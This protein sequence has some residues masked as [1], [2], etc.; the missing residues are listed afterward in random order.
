MYFLIKRDSL[1]TSIISNTKHSPHRL[2]LLH[3]ELKD[4]E[5]TLIKSLDEVSGEGVY[6]MEERPNCYRIFKRVILPDGYLFSGSHE[7][8]VIFF[9]D[10]VHY[11]LVDKVNLTH[12]LCLNQELTPSKEKNLPP[13]LYDEEYPALPPKLSRQNAY[14]VEEMIEE[15]K[16]VNAV[17]KCIVRD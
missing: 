1:T 17:K 12:E 10:L 9:Y 13:G 16:K 2:T 3:N 7:D 8:F 5:I 14:T 6:C 11:K 15:T 4:N